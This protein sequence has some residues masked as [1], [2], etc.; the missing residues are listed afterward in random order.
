MSHDIAQLEMEAATRLQNARRDFD[1]LK[2]DEEKYLKDRESKVQ[3]LLADLMRRGDSAF[4]VLTD[5]TDHIGKEM[6]E[7]TARFAD[8]AKGLVSLLNRAEN[9]MDSANRIEERAKDTLAIYQKMN[10]DLVEKTSQLS[11]LEKQIKSREREVER[12]DKVAEAKLSEAKE[13][14]YWHKSGKRY[15]KK[16]I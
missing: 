6:R 14:A 16:S 12:R 11:E 15:N 5:I 8:F 7:H 3:T 1:A 10:A 4:K 2:R 9:I 13:L